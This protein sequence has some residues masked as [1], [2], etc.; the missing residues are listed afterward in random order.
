MAFDGEVESAQNIVGDGITAELEDDGAWAVLG[1]DF[2]HYGF[3]ELLVGI[4]VDADF[5]RHV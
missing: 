2:V 3:E 1:H 4:V 5:E